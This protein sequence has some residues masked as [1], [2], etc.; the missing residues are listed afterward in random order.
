MVERTRPGSSLNVCM[1]SSRALW[2]ISNCSFLDLEVCTVEVP[3]TT[4]H[5]DLLL[6]AATITFK[7]YI[8][9]ARIAAFQAHFTRGC[10]RRPRHRLVSGVGAHV[11]CF[12][13]HC[14]AGDPSC[15]VDR[16]H[17]GAALPASGDES[18]RYVHFAL[19]VKHGESVNIACKHATCDGHGRVS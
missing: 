18:A 17:S 7:D 19:E 8:W 2:Y 1:L 12:C 9:T 14:T 10:A 4:S 3:H 11:Y 16:H 15:Q 6:W 13:A 5:P